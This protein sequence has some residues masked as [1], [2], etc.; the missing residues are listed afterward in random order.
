MTNDEEFFIE[1]MDNMTNKPKSIYEKNKFDMNDFFEETMAID[2][3][4][5]KDKLNDAKAKQQK[6]NE[7]EFEM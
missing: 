6:N 3:A 1:M 2:D 4:F 5:L 7:S